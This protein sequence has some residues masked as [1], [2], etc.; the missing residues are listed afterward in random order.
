MP[1]I[2]PVIHNAPP[3]PLQILTNIKIKY[4]IYSVSWNGHGSMLGGL[5][6][7]MHSLYIN[8][9]IFFSNRMNLL[10]ELSK[11]SILLSSIHIPLLCLHTN[12]HQ[13]HGNMYT[14]GRSQAAL[15]Y[16]IAELQQKE[17]LLTAK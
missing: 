13:H 8:I 14:G 10:V 15:W 6:L 9:D 12:E 11:L 16:R 5:R 1:P 7:L 2:L 3:T 17:V 4:K